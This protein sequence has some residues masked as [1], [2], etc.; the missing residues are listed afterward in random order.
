MRRIISTLDYIYPDTFKND[1]YLLIRTDN[2]N[3]PYDIK[4]SLQE[5]IDHRSAA[6]KNNN[7]IEMNNYAE[8][9][10]WDQ[11]YPD[12]P[13]SYDYP[14]V[15]TNTGLVLIF[16][17]E[18]KFHKLII[19]DLL[20]DN[21]DDPKNKYKVKSITY[22]QDRV[23]TRR[24][25]VVN[26]KFVMNALFKDEHGYYGIIDSM[27]TINI[28]APY[29][30]NAFMAEHND[31]KFLKDEKMNQAVIDQGF[32]FSTERT[33][34][35]IIL[36]SKKYFRTSENVTIYGPNNDSVVCLNDN[37]TVSTNTE[38]TFWYIKEPFR[39]TDGI[40]F[41]ILKCAGNNSCILEVS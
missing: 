22:P 30:N 16:Y 21:T 34:D 8:D 27:K 4:R 18:Y 2:S 31:L 37:G 40:G 17:D 38:G 23:E 41:I 19:Y 1:S 36:P 24:Y 9:Y 15:A 25:S 3:S 7:Y 26:G 35:Y 14:N 13:E 39:T 20:V 10:V 6:K 29:N 33:F 5:G 11:K 28:D 12:I 32:T